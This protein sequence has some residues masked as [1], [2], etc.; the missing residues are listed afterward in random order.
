LR[1]GLVVLDTVPGMVAARRLYASLGFAECAPYYATSPLV[2]PVF[3]ERR[4]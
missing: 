3:M 4:L 1:L 2:A